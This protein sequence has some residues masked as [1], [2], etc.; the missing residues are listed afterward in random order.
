MSFRDS[1]DFHAS[2]ES[3]S[4]FLGREWKAISAFGGMFAAASVAV[5]FAVDP[6][7]FYPRLQTDPLR[8]LLKAHAFMETGS[9]ITRAAVNVPPFLYASAPGVMRIPLLI[10]FRDF[11]QQLRAIQLTHVLFVL[12]VASMCAYVLSWVV[13]KNYHW[14]AVGF[15]F[16]FCALAPWWTANVLYPLADAPYAAFSLGSLIVARAIL[17]SDKPIG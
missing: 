11:D 9:T 13:P 4:S 16:A 7:Y 8:Y 3:F 10:A 2:L 12:A 6:A 15:S 17:T 1:H 5:I 14:A